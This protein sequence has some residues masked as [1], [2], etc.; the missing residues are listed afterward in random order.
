MGILNSRLPWDAANPLKDAWNYQ[1]KKVDM[2]NGPPNQIGTLAPF[3]DPQVRQAA[4]STGKARQAQETIGRA[5]SYGTIGS[6]VGG[7]AGTM[8]PIPVLGP[9]IGSAAGGALGQLVGGVTPDFKDVLG[10]GASG[11]VGGALGAGAGALMPGMVSGT[12]GKIV[13]YAIGQGVL[14]RL[15][16]G[17]GFNTQY[18][19]AHRYYYDPRT[20]QTVT[21]Y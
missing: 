20:Q 6:I 18:D 19:P 14:G 16:Q 9:A 21:S 4:M 1:T 8:I 5:S 10:Y 11:S 2:S 3:N 15:G 7:M 13:P 12:L 17:A